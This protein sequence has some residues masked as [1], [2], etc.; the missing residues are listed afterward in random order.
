M[1][2]V[3]AALD[4]EVAGFIRRRGL[5]RAEGPDGIEAFEGEGAAALISGVGKERAE[6]AAEIAVSRYSPDVVVSA[7]VGGATTEEYKTGD[8]LECG[9]VAAGSALGIETPVIE[10]DGDGAH[11]CL[12]VPGLIGYP[13]SKRA[14][15]LMDV[16]VVDMESYWVADTAVRRGVEARVV[17]AII[18]EV[19]YEIPAWVWGMKKRGGALRMLARRPWRTPAL[20]KLAWKAEVAERALNRALVSMAG[21]FI[22]G[23]VGGREN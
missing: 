2:V 20:M 15:G 18:D 6:R 14:I 8:V 23:R 17:R 3:I 4:L 5:R 19:D 1:F 22:Y 13:E 7:G 12:T 16:A 9:R 10:M 21:E 11:L